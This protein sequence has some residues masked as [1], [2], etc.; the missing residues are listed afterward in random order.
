MKHMVLIIQPTPGRLATFDVKL[1]SIEPVTALFDTGATCYCIS[2]SLYNQLSDKVQIVQ[3]QL[4][5]GQA[6]GMSLCPIWNSK[7]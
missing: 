6:D 4:Q 5:V 7:G 3:M 2:F 1:F